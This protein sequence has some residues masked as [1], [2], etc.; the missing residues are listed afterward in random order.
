M[1]KLGLVVFS[2]FDWSIFTTH[3]ERE[4]RLLYTRDKIIRDQII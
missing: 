4:E 3:P 2:A 1:D